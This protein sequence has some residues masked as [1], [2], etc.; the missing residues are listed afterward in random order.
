[1][2]Q[3]NKFCSNS[4]KLELPIRLALFISPLFLLSQKSLHKMKGRIDIVDVM[5]V[6]FRQFLNVSF[7]LKFPKR[8]E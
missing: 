3:L 1:M 5:K 2:E 6:S 4:D 7:Q 8:Q